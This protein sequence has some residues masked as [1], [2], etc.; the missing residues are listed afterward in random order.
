[1]AR[2]IWALVSSGRHL[3]LSVMWL[4][5]CWMD[6][7]KPLLLELPQAFPYPNHEEWLTDPLNGLDRRL[8]PPRMILVCDHDGNGQNR[9]TKTWPK[10]RDHL[11]IIHTRPPFSRWRETIGSK[12]FYIYSHESLK[13]YNYFRVTSFGGISRWFWHWSYGK[14]TLDV[15]MCLSKQIEQSFSWNHRLVYMK[16][17]LLFWLTSFLE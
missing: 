16:R 2:M 15:Y 6:R 13:T 8:H 9:I 11:L 4:I 7:G 1:M 3:N 17:R 10:G 12:M 5:T 14:V